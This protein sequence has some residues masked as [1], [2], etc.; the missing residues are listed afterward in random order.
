MSTAAN[1]VSTGG[2]AVDK[3]GTGS[4]QIEAPCAARAQSML[5]QAGGG[6]KKHVRRNG[7]ENDCVDFRRIDASLGERATGRLNG[8]VRSR[9]AGL[10]NVALPDSGALLNPLVVRVDHVLQIRIRQHLRGSIATERSNFSL[11]QLGLFL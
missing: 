6:G 7:A 2:Q 10:G 8:H 9:H 5:D 11:G 1:Q 3:T 4:D